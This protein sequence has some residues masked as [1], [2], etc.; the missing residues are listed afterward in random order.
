MTGQ[1]KIF[2][3]TD[4]KGRLYK[5]IWLPYLSASQQFY[6]VEQNSLEIYS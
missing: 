2:Y 1:T 4:C 3:V 5:S 6:E